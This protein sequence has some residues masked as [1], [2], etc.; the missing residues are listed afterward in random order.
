MKR[1]AT[2]QMGK[3][4]VMMGKVARDPKLKEWSSQVKRAA[5]L[6]LT[7]PRVRKAA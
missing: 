2:K 6:L 5:A 4:A 1:I 3:A 7:H